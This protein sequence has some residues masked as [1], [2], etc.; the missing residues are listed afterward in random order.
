MNKKRF[1]DYQVMMTSLIPLINK[2]LALKRRRTISKILIMYHDIIFLNIR[3]ELYPF[4]CL[5]RFK[6]CSEYLVQNSRNIFSFDFKTICHDYDVE[7]LNIQSFRIS[8]KLITSYRQIPWMWFIR[9]IARNGCK[10]EVSSKPGRFPSKEH[11]FNLKSKSRAIESLLF[12]VWNIS[13]K[14]NHCWHVYR[15]SDCIV[16]KKWSYRIQNLVLC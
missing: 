15:R 11:I 10:L 2:I 13:V 8:L 16:H 1:V 14:S 4:I 9:E 7:A 12:T 6:R 5:I 3:R